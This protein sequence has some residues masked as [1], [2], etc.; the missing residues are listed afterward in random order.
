[1]RSREKRKRKR[2]KKKHTGGTESNGREPP[3]GVMEGQAQ[4][5]PPP[6]AVGKALVGA[7]TK[8]MAS[9][10]GTR[11]WRPFRLAAQG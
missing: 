11:W 1:M 7:L 9:R 5:R 8:E 2:K 10:A 6:R 4:R 3:G